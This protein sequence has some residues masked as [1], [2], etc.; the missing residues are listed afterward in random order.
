MLAP[1]SAFGI[2]H[3]PADRHRPGAGHLRGR[4]APDLGVPGRPASRRHS[5]EGGR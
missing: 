2:E 4:P 5:H 3:S 1:G